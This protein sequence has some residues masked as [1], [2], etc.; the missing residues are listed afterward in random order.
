MATVR[1]Q[2]II[3]AIIVTCFFTLS[4]S[5]DGFQKSHDIGSQHQ[6]FQDDINQADSESN[7]MKKFQAIFDM[8]QVAEKQLSKADYKILCQ[9]AIEE[10]LSIEEQISQP[11]FKKNLKKNLNGLVTDE[12]KQD[13]IDADYTM[14]LQKSLDRLT[15]IKDQ[16]IGQKGQESS[17]KDKGPLQSTLDKLKSTAEKQLGTVNLKALFQQPLNIFSSFTGQLTKEQPDNASQKILDLFNSAKEQLVKGREH[18]VVQR[19]L[20]TLTAAKDQIVQVNLAQLP[21]E[22]KDWIS[23]HPYQTAFHIVN[24]IVY[25]YPPALAGPLFWAAGLGRW[26]TR[27]GK[28]TDHN[29]I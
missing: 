5:L 22:V 17:V 14:V 8:T 2:N 16:L 24:G 29:F 18:V 23:A 21:A 26:G 27:A 20:S 6:A 1:L 28:S 10:V 11:A 25:F 12:G 7:Y 3:L 19:T 9:R 13:V 4:L 15:M